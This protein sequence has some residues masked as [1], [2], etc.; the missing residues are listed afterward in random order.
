KETKPSMNAMMTAK[1]VHFRW[2]KL[3]RMVLSIPGTSRGFRERATI[4]EGEVVGDKWKVVGIGSGSSGLK[5]HGPYHLSPTTYHLTCA[6][7]EPSKSRKSRCLRE[8]GS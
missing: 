1:S 5:W 2:W 4:A 3:S 7:S 8:K 6:I